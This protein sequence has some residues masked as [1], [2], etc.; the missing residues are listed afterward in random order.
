MTKGL[1]KFESK[2]DQREI[3]LLSRQA[4]N[5]KQPLLLPKIRS[6]NFKKNTNNTRTYNRNMKTFTLISLLTSI[7]AV[8]AESHLA[9][10]DAAYK[11]FG[12]DFNGIGDHSH[13][14]LLLG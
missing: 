10:V 2:H 9:R 1:P 13:P 14:Y 5:K 12:S 3:L 4:L 8:T 7:Y 6:R 11:A